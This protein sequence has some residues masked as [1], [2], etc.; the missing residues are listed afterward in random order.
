MKKI[1]MHSSISVALSIILCFCMAAFHIYPVKAADETIL[2]ND[3][4]MYEEN[5]SETVNINGINYTYQYS[6]DENNNRTICI[7]N[8]VDSF[9]DRITYLKE[10]GEIYLNNEILG[11]VKTLTSDSEKIDNYTSRDAFVYFG[12]LN[13]YISWAKGTTAAAVAAV[14]A[15]ALPS[16]GA[17]GVI[18]A[19]GTAALGV[20]AASSIGGTVKGSIYRLN[21]TYHIQYKYV[22][23]FTASNGD[24]YGTY[25][26][27][28]PVG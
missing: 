24:R 16:L 20:L 11:K 25:T 3:Q 18:A 17:A 15:V 12:P 8:D 9:V 4:M 27:F 14:I 26:S 22:W 7:T 2:P 28:T 10:T 23:S 1:K 19:M 6:L 21:S 13:E 5:S